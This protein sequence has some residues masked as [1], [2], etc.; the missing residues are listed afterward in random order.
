MRDG[1]RFWRDDARISQSLSD[2]HSRVIGSF[3]P[4]FLFINAKCVRVNHM[5]LQLFLLALHIRSSGGICLS[6]TDVKTILFTLVALL[7]G[8][9]LLF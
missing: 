9:F 6:Q 2:F 1:G 5:L 4:D 3:A 8:K 7:L